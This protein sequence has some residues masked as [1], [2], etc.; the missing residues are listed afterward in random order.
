MGPRSHCSPDVDKVS[1]G[2]RDAVHVMLMG[3]WSQG[4]GASYTVSVE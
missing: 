3:W 1:G 4:M 2:V